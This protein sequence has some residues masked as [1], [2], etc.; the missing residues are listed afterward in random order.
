MEATY[1]IGLMSGTSLDG[2]DVVL[3]DLRTT[4]PLLLGTHFCPYNNDLRE[5]LLSLHQSD[6]D[7]LHRAAMLSNQLSY[8]FAEATTGLLE[9]AG[10][11]PEQIIAIGC[12]GQTIR[13][14]PEPDKGYTI[15]LVNAALLAE[16]TRITVVTDLR[17]RDIAAGGQGAPL[18]PAFHEAVFKKSDCHRVI[19]NIGGIANITNLDPHHF[20]TGFDCG[21]GNVLMDA[22]CLQHI[23]KIYDKNGLWAATGQV[24]PALL[25]ALLADPFFAHKP[26]KSTG[27]DLF[28]LHWLEQKMRGSESPENVQAT[29]LQVTVMSISRSIHTYCL[30]AE[31][32][33][34]CGGGGHNSF[35]MSQLT[36]VMQGK[37]VALTDRL[38]ITIDW[39]EA[40]AFAWLA[41]QAI[42]RK[43]GNLTG[44]TGAKGGRILGAIYPA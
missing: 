20:V 17:S 42:L 34:I 1:Y 14:C 31:E 41:Q 3:V 24:V 4:P 5:A 36:E 29:L 8:L 44:V 15:Q 6:Y 19:V 18:V 28:N 27:R 35:L 21:P 25:D 11:F 32:I 2:V 37:K 23:G 39:V 26:P 13:H 38:G 12:H 22:W 7:E 10:V 9:S 43:A 30:G 33:Y 40:F 16:L